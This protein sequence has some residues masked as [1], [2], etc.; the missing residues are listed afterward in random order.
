M[1]DLIC[2]VTNG[3]SRSFKYVDT[4][5][6][7]VRVWQSCGSC[8]AVVWCLYAKSRRRD[9]ATG[10][11]ICESGS[12]ESLNHHS[13]NSKLNVFHLGFYNDNIESNVM[14]EEIK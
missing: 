6:D 12:T 7:A 5:C 4:A 2:G 9:G 11:V 14:R 3:V 8:V 10:H 1:S 13:N